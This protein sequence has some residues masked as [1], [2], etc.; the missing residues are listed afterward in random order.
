ML[1]VLGENETFRTVSIHPLEVPDGVI[2]IYLGAKDVTP[3]ANNSLRYQIMIEVPI[4]A[5]RFHIG[6]VAGISIPRWVHRQMCAVT[7]RTVISVIEINHIVELVWRNQERSVIRAVGADAAIG[8][9][10]RLGQ[11]SD[12][13]A[14]PASSAVASVDPALRMIALELLEHFAEILIGGERVG[15]VGTGCGSD[16][17]TPLIISPRAHTVIEQLVLPTHGTRN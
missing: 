16:I 4:F 9:F 8:I 15:I 7:S 12:V 6:P 1:L 10:A 11:P 5:D 2:V 3:A 14:D 13:I 17:I